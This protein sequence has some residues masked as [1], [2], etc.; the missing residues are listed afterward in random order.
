MEVY[1]V[2]IK[3]TGTG[4]AITFDDIGF[5]PAAVEIIIAGRNVTGGVLFFWTDKM[6]NGAGYKLVANSSGNKAIFSA[7]SSG[8]VT[9]LP[10]G[11][12]LGADTDVNVD[13]EV[14]QI[15]VRR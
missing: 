13:G 1:N 6:A 5:T 15:I 10:N 4:A 7:M 12:I 9:P 2:T 8:G 14:M 3:A 11:F